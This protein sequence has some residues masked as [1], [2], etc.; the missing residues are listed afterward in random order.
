MGNW[1]TNLFFDEEEN[2]ARE[3]V[4]WV[5]GFGKVVQ[6][7][8]LGSDA[9]AEVDRTFLN[10]NIQ[11]LSR[12]EEFIRADPIMALQTVNPLVI[13]KWIAIWDVFLT[14]TQGTEA[15]V[16]SEMEAAQSEA[17]LQYQFY[18]EYLGLLIDNAQVNREVLS[19]VQDSRTAD[20]WGK[21]SAIGSSLVELTERLSEN[22]VALEEILITLE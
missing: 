14:S 3:W 20:T 15:A 16:R 22:D 8:E 13:D 7:Y 10:P 6:I 1:Y 11:D 2:K 12:R 4:Y 5:P 17:A 9:Y 18:L 21:L 19:L